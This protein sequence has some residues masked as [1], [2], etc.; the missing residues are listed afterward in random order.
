MNKIIFISITGILS[1]LNFKKVIAY[2]RLDGID[3]FGGDL[4]P[5]YNVN[6]S[7]SCMNLC[8]K[9]R[10]CKLVSYCDN[11]CYIKNIKTNQ[12]NKENCISYDMFPEEFNYSDYSIDGSNNTDEIIV[13]E[14]PSISSNDTDIP[15]ETTTPNTSIETPAPDPIETTTP[16]SKAFRKYSLGAGCVF[17]AISGLVIYI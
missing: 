16:T 11:V 5:I 4:Y 3:F 15:I 2:E 13:P 7:L 10:D 14:A 1:L 9:I 17:I 8:E 12:S 6:E